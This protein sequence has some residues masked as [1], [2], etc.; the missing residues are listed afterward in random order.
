MVVFQ[1]TAAQLFRKRLGN[2]LYDI[3]LNRRTVNSTGAI[4]S[5]RLWVY[6][7]L[8]VNCLSL[9]ETKTFLYKPLTW[10]TEG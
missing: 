6:V 9:R 4:V 7:S 10:L 8:V 5:E 1:L 3:P 2:V